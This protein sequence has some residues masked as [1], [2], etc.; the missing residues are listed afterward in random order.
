M[1]A[2][3]AV[4]LEVRRLREELAVKDRELAA[5]D[6]ELDELRDKMID[7]LA[8]HQEQYAELRSWLESTTN[9]SSGT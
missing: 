5:K 6:T 9:R 3:G 2:P 4:E 8:R 7:M 1:A